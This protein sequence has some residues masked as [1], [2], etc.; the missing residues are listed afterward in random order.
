MDGIVVV[1]G[2][3]GAG[4][5]TILGRLDKRKYTVVNIGTLMTDIAVKR[6]LVRNRDELRGL[7]SRKELYSK[8]RNEAFSGVARMKGLVIVDTH[9]SVESGGRYVPGLPMEALK[10]LNGLRGFIYVDAAP[11]EVL[12]RRLHDRTRKRDR[13][14][15]AVETQRLINLA[16]LSFHASY[17]NI[18]LHII[19][20][21]QG[22]L[23]SSVKKFEAA[24]S[25]LFKG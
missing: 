25:D 22:E 2:S 23:E 15:N 11:K 24:L 16:S 21:R 17:L 4:K 8:L 10:L 7:S 3:P 20:N 6:G 14:E 5:T 13:G 9:A 19:N 12:E 18:S 1:T